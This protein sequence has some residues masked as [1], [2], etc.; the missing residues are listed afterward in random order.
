MYFICTASA[1]VEMVLIGPYLQ[2]QSYIL[3]GKQITSHM[4]KHL[5]FH[6]AVGCKK[7]FPV[8]IPSGLNVF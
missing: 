7:G 6:H 4:G 8:L 1:D 5:A 2:V 3:F